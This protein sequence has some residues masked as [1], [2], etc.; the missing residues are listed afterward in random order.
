M[1]KTEASGSR[2][3]FARRTVLAAGAAAA[4][5]LRLAHA[6]GQKLKI[7]LLLARSGIQAQIGIDCQRGADCAPEILKS[8]G[9]PDF[10][11][12]QGD[13]ES[14]ADIARVQAEKLI[15]QGCTV[16]IGCFDSSQTLTTAQV[17]EQRSI[18]FVVNISS[19]TALTEQGYKTVFRNF[20]TGPMIA[21]DSF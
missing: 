7:G 12:V 21:A 20:P 10:E 9:Y 15:D 14:K 18:P 11:I 3:V 8:K 4:L 6:Q 16:L 2:R 17:C 13:T 1:S 5:P 19:V